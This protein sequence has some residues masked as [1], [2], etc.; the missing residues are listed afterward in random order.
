MGFEK[1][2][3]TDGMLI[4]LMYYPV[5]TLGPGKR[6]G[7]WTQGCSIHCKGCMSEHTWDFD[8]N[9]HLPWT[10]IKSKLIENANKSKSLTISG[11]EPFDQFDQLIFLLKLARK[12]G[13]NDIL[14]YTGYTVEE[15]KNKFGKEFEKIT[16][17][18]SALIDGRFVQGL[19]SEL[20]WKGSENQRMFI[21]EKDHNIRKMYE[22]YLL[23]RKNR[24]LQLI[25]YKETLL[26]VGI[27]YQKNEP[28]CL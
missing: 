24:K 13:Y 12:T 21:Y 15:L 23:K 9:K 17:L 16:K 4:S 19:D 3:T 18:T 25:S 11:G 27:P 8:E 6:L 26:L 14:L 1:H 5:L 20:I 28:F 7:I 10:L 22:D 2:K